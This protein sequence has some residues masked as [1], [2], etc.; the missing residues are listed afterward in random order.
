MDGITDGRMDSSACVRTS[1]G[2]FVILNASRQTMAKN[3]ILRI[4]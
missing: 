3:E 4:W 1:G 2:L